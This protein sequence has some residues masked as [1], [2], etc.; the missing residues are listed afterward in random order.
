MI[1]RGKYIVYWDQE[2]NQKKVAYSFDRGGHGYLVDFYDIAPESISSF[3][4]VQC[5]KEKQTV[6]IIENAVWEN[7][8]ES[9]V[10]ADVFAEDNPIVIKAFQEYMAPDNQK[11]DLTAYFRKQKER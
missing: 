9:K 3:G 10:W 5:E 6:Q 7:P 4:V 8:G 2:E 1:E 11:V